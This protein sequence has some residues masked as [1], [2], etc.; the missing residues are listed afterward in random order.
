MG[1]E[2]NFIE[3]LNR[4]FESSDIK[5]LKKL[6]DSHDMRVR[7]AVAK[8]TNIDTSIA[9]ELLYDPVLNVSY[10]ASLNPNCTLKRSFSNVNLNNKCILCD[11]DERYIDCVNCFK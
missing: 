11:E 1:E 5:E 7:R 4:A 10:M 2:I 6:K 9:N 3:Q 8:N